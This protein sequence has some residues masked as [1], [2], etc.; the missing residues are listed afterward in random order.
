M[1]EKQPIGMLFN[2]IPFYDTEEL[3]NLID[4]L[5]EEQMKHIISQSLQYSYKSGIFNLVE[6]ELVSKSLRILKN[7]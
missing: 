3:T 2:N 1:E 7:L 6:A 5:S 4:N